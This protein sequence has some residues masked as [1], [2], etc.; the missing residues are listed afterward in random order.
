VFPIDIPVRDW[1]AYH[2]VARPGKTAV[3]CVDTGESRTWAEFDPRVGAVAGGLRDAL[4]IRPGDRVCLL[5]EN[6]VRTFELHFACVRAARRDLRPA[7][8]AP[9]TE[10]A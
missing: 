9:G 5:A 8:L 2:A 3:H 6:D 10:A 1:V 4:G 7:E